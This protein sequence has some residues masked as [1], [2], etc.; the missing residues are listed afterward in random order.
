MFSIIV[1]LL[2]QYYIIYF[3]KVH[4]LGLISWLFIKPRSSVKNFSLLSKIGA[5]P[6]FSYIVNNQYVISNEGKYKLYNITNF[7]DLF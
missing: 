5:C 3:I 7:T 2:T 4:N 6:W 1:K